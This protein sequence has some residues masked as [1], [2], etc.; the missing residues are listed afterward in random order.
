MEFYNSG[1]YDNALWWRHLGAQDSATNLLWDFQMQLDD[2]AATYTQALE[3][4]SYQFLDGYN[5][6]IG[7]Q[8]DYPKQVWDTYDAA[9]ARWVVTSIPCPKFTANTWHH[10]QWYVTTDHTAHTYTYVTLVVDGKSIPVNQTYTAR[11]NGW[12]H[13][14]GVQWQLDTN[15]KG[16]GYHEWVDQASLTVW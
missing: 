4:D 12:N 6:M 9:N 15:S 10:I 3:Y 14:V 2:A 13:D 7:S 16:G 11:Y 1:T 5:Y 8:C